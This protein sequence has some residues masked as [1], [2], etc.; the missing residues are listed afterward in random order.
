MHD[1]GNVEQIDVAVVGL[2]RMGMALCQ[3]LATCGFAVT[4]TDIRL[5]ARPEAEA[6]GARWSDSLLAAA[7]G[8]RFVITCLPGDAEVEPMIRELPQ[9][10]R[11]GAVWIEMSTASPGVARRRDAAAAAD[12]IQA[13][14]APVGGNPDA[15]VRGQ[16]LCFVG[17]EAEVLRSARPVLEAVADRIVHVGPA[18]A[19]YLVKLLANSIWFT[20]AVATAEALALAAR[21]GLDPETAR[22]AFAQTAAGGRF[23][24]HDAPAFL[25]GDNYDSFSLPRCCDQLAAVVELGAQ[26]A[27]Q[28]SVTAEVADLHRQALARYGEVD[29]ELLGARWVAERAGLDFR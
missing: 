9:A 4:G 17:G 25:R 20:Q 6:I 27:M 11:T 28:M 29:G 7:A 15:A 22:A 10:M 26:L 12:G 3:R 14:D 8:A 1:V 5:E 23:L 19:G 13:L 24:T 21:A 2:G 18:G 16:L